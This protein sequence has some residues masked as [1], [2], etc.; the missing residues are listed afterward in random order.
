MM[1]SLVIF[2]IALLSVPEAF[3]V[4]CPAPYCKDGTTNSWNCGAGKG[5]P[6][7]PN[8]CFFITGCGCPKCREA[9]ILDQCFKYC[10]N[11]EIGCEA[12]CYGEP[13][14]EEICVEKCEKEQGVCNDDCER[15]FP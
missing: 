7:W 15:K 2:I 1:K 14:A 12:I 9:K 11:V 6:F 8:G 5:R 10:D 13:W 4:C 3:A